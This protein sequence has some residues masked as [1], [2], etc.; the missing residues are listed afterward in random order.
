MAD[1]LQSGLLRESAQK[2]RRGD[3][4]AGKGDGSGWQKRDLWNGLGGLG[5]GTVEG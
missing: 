4:V 2:A 5:S 3:D 1:A